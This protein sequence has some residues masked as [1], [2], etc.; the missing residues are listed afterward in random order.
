[1]IMMILILEL[2]LFGAVTT[3]IEKP[4]KWVKHG[5]SVANQERGLGRVR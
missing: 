5:V 4:V 2:N 3:R 1:M